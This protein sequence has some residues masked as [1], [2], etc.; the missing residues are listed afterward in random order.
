MTSGFQGREWE[1]DWTARWKVLLESTKD[2]SLC[3]RS[4]SFPSPAVDEV[5]FFAALNPE[6]SKPPKFFFAEEEDEFSGLDD[7]EDYG[8]PVER[9]LYSLSADT[10]SREFLRTFDYQAAL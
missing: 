1:I 5:A 4:N 2:D 10:L 6:R 9:P 3:L 8:D 7:D